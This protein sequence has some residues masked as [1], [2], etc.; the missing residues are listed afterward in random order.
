M[1]Q[2]KIRNSLPA[3]KQI[4]VVTVI[5]FDANIGVNHLKKQKQKFRNQNQSASP[6]ENRI[7]FHESE[8]RKRQT[9]RQ[10]PG[11]Q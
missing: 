1:D 9:T 5:V 2:K 11:S 10:V 3:S 7:F 6:Q 8:I 4:L